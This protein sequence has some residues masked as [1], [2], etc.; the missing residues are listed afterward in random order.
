MAL[1]KK[2]RVALPKVPMLAYLQ[3]EG[4]I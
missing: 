1:Q 2:P 4:M 3:I